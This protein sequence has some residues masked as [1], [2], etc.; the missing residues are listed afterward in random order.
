VYP[1][2]DLTA[3][4]RERGTLETLIAAP[5]PRLG[6]LL[7]KYV[8]VLT[9]A[10]LTAT[11][12]LLAMAITSHS[13]G[14]NASLFGGAGMTL[15]M[16]VK[17]LLLLGLFAAFFSAVLLAVTSM[18]RSFKEAQAYIIPLMLLCLVPGIVC[19]AP[20]L[21][22]TGLLAVIPLVN[23]VVL[24]RDLLEG[25]VHSALAAAAVLSTMLYVLAAIALAA[26]VFGSD[27]I[28][29]GGQ[30]TW[31]DFFRRPAEPRSTARPTTIMFI[32]AA[33]FPCYFVLGNELARSVGLSIERRLIVAALVTAVVFGV[34]PW[35]VARFHRVSVRTG[36]GL[37]VSSAGALLAAALLGVS[38]WPAAHEL[39][40]FGEWLGV[41]TLQ[42][43]QVALVENLVDEWQAVPWMLIVVTLAIV[44]AVF[45]EC[46]FRGW[47]FTSLRSIMRPLGTIV[48][49]A[50]M[51]G[52]FHVVAAQ[53]LAV[54]RF[55][56][57]T[58]LGLVLGWVRYRTGSVWPC[59][60]LHA[61]HNGLLLSITY[62]QDALQQRGIGVEE[63]VHLPA[64]WLLVA[65]GVAAVGVALLVMSTRVSCSREA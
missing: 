35:S 44:P 26:R 3:G 53:V 23:I 5:V 60:L 18:A 31:S 11:V 64:T 40:L 15:A 2:I 24:A 6:L 22:F 29:Y 30:A 41:W 55:L 42:A 17:V 21:K 10:L 43:D 56:P 65:G 9:V 14:L 61:V 63:A 1:A 20:S 48:A 12:N 33:I 36:V 28:L 62:W 38:A 49:A 16:V 8:A 7:A 19:L 58:F 51:F 4:E 50:V 13:T 39:F 27:A 45:E 54:E 47:L 32:L 52:L 34:I 59:I 25:G 37:G 46:F 57:S